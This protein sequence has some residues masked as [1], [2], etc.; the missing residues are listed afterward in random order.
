M[1]SLMFLLVLVLFCC[2]QETSC[3][4]LAMNSAKS[5]CCEATTDKNIPLKQIMSYQWTTSTCPIKAI[6]FKTIAGRKICVDPQNTLVKNQVAKLDKRTSSTTALS[7]ESTST[8]AE[9]PAATSAAASSSEFTS[10]TSSQAST[11]ATA[12]SHESTSA[13]S[14]PE[15]TSVSKSSP[16]STSAK[17]SPASTSATALSPEYTSASTVTFTTE[18]H[19]TSDQ[20]AVI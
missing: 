12:L 13:T 11:S 9:T 20:S 14:S 16:E 7:P 15:S 10:A 5:V 2:V 8:T 3:A 1:R 18:S 4:P 19:S 6:V 17:S